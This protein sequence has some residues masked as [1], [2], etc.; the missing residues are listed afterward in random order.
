MFLVIASCRRSDNADSIAPGQDFDSYLAEQV[1]GQNIPALSVLMFKGSEIKYEKYLGVADKTTNVPLSDAHV[2]LLA[3]ISKTVTATALMQLFEQGK[4]SLDDKINDYLP[5]AVKIPGHA[6]PVSFRMLLTHTSAIADGKALDDQYYYNR[7]S[8][9]PLADFLK[10]YLTPAGKYYNA[11]DNFYDFE[12]GT[13]Q[14]YSN[15]GSALIAVL[16]ESISGMDFPTYCKQ[17][18]F[19]PL[20]MNNTYWKLADVPVKN[21]VRPYDGNQAIDHYT[22]TDYPNGGLRTSVRDMFRFLSAY[23][24][25]GIFNGTQI[26]KAATVHEM[27]KQQIPSI[28]PTTG[29]H[30]FIM[31][32]SRNIWGHDG[33]EQGVA[34]IMGVNPDTKVGVLIFTNQGN[35]DL[36]NLLTAAYDHAEKL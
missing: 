21:L 9:V 15:E 13:M 10:D 7:D 1:T 12:P 30:W 19:A 20:G 32:S 23:G 17:N 8:P 3:S 6:T 2:F 28:D 4:F 18:I 26:L 36:D 5:F 11:K 34:T 16:V 31:N 25:E 27:L 33:G 35:A 29:L 24:N 22:F 14:E